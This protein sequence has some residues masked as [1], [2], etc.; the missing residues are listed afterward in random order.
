M[1]AG[2]VGG[3]N[4]Y[5]YDGEHERVDHVRAFLVREQSMRANPKSMIAAAKRYGTTT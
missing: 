1:G 5:F 3:F 4:L 2:G